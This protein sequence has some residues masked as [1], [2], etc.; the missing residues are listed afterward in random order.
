MFKQAVAIAVLALAGTIDAQWCSDCKWGVNKLVSYVE[1]HGNTDACSYV[2]KEVQSYSHN[3]CGAE[4]GSFVNRM[5]QQILT[6]IESTAGNDLSSDNI[7]AVGICTDVHAC[8]SESSSRERRTSRSWAESF[9]RGECAQYPNPSECQPACVNDIVN[10][11]MSFRRA[12]NAKMAD[13]AR[14]NPTIQL[15]NG[16]T[17][18]CV[19]DPTSRQFL[20]SVN[21]PTA[22]AAQSSSQDSKSSGVSSGATI[23]I[24]V[25]AVAT[26]LVIAGLAFKAVAES[27]KQAT[28]VSAT[29]HLV[30]Q[31]EYATA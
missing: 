1:V 14:Q 16:A 3:L 18:H 22:L 17:G 13:D 11:A 27:K 8:S 24:A 25:G 26:V 12:V 15:S 2:V 10:G 30:Q 7:D 20:C 9:C 4:C 21:H 5:C 28:P 29:E 6:K 31:D 19:A 23:G